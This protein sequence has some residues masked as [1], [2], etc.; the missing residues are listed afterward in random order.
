MGNAVFRFNYIV[1]ANACKSDKWDI[2]SYRILW[3]TY[4]VHMKYMVLRFN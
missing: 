3:Q 4:A 1:R 2:I